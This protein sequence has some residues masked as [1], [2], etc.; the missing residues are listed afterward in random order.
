VV[1]EGEEVSA[2]RLMLRESTVPMQVAIVQAVADAVRAL[3]GI[4]VDAV[5]VCGDA[6]LASPHLISL[7]NES[8]ARNIPVVVEGAPALDLPP[9][10]A[11]YF[12]P[13]RGAR[14]VVALVKHTLAPR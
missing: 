3:A 13:E 11:V 8:A 12:C 4:S 7:V 9:H 2:V 6:A 14:A 5:A 1:G 10:P